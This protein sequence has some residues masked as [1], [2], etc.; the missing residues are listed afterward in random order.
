MHISTNISF[1]R[2]LLALQMAFTIKP[3]IIVAK[4]F[5]ILGIHDIILA[6]I[7]FSVLCMQCMHSYIQKNYE[8]TLTSFVT[9]CL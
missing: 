6:A 2:N 1:Y 8:K 9:D 5:G 7:K 3:E 4:I